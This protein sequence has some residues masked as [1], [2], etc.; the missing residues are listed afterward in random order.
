M[1]KRLVKYPLENGQFIL[2]EVDEP[3]EV[4]TVRV[5]RVGDKIEEAKETLEQALSNLEP[6]A[7]AVINK[8]RGLVDAPDEIS[9][10]FG[11][12][13]S[14]NVGVILASASVEANY[15]VSLKWKKE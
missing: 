8:I 3:E 4:G 12:K 2:V 9:V 14:G 11:L 7:K 1:S 15:K 6:V 13:L 5:G 10:E